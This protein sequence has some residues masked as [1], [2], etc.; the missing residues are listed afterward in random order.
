M[1]G[2]RIYEKILPLLKELNWFPVATQLYLRTV[3]MVFK[4]LTGRV[5][6]YL[7]SQFIT[8][9]EISGRTTRNSQK[10]N[11]PLF[12]SASGQRTSYYRIVYSQRGSLKTIN[13]MPVFKYSLK[14]EL[15]KDFINS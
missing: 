12:K 9:K 8:R 13:S 7:S 15:L 3:I 14:R 1:T 4:C 5:P 10:L 6:E 11:N 2:T